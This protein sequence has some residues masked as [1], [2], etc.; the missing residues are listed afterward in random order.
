MGVYRGYDAVVQQPTVTLADV[1]ARAGSTATRVL[2]LVATVPA[3]AFEEV[4]P[5]S[6]KGVADP[7]PLY[8]V[9]A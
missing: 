2:E 1:A 6:L 3:A 9:R 8:R 4:G 7:V 5:T